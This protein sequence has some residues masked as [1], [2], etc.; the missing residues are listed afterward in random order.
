V[1]G[2]SGSADLPAALDP[3]FRTE[4]HKQHGAEPAWEAAGDTQPGRIPEGYIRRAAAK[5][6]VVIGDELLVMLDNQIVRLTGIGPA[7]WETSAS[8]IRPDQLAKAV[9][10]V[11]GTPEGYRDAVATA[12]QQLIATSVL[13]QGG[14]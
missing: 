5:D 8:P 2:E 11:H 9:G 14:E 1:S 13:E 3:L 7:I 4:L 6:A 12:T 10:E